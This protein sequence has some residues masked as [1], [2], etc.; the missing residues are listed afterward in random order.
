MILRIRYLMINKCIQ[1]KTPPVAVE[2]LFAR[3]ETCQTHKM[4]YNEHCG[5]CACTSQHNANGMHGADRIIF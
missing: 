4:W 3:S 2:F 5:D 1:I